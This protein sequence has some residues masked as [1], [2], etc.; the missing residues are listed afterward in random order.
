LGEEPKITFENSNQT[1]D[2]F[3]IILVTR[4]GKLIVFEC[5]T[6]HMSGDNAK[7]NKYSTYAVGGV[8]GLLVLLVPLL[9]KEEEEIKNIPD[10]ASNLKQAI[11][12]AKRANLEVWGID[13]IQGK[14]K[15]E[16]QK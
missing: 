13:E 8:Y 16:I 9:N 1:I 4:G 5:K 6:G 2:E 14:L 15:K 12:S 3:D 10:Y 7:S 11:S